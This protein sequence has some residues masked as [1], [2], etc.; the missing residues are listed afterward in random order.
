MSSTSSG[1]PND[2]VL[3]PSSG[4]GKGL[5]YRLQQALRSPSRA[6]SSEE[7]SAGSESG[8]LLHVEGAEGHGRG[9]STIDFTEGRNRPAP[10]S[11]PEDAGGAFLKS[12]HGRQVSIGAAF[13]QL[14]SMTQRAGDGSTLFRG[15]EEYVERTHARDEGW[16]W[17]ERGARGGGGG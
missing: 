8:D 2:A 10:R 6:G 12:G 13:A 4:G 5:H 11:Q 3:T 1:S 15:Y 9:T 17:V 14:Q 7:S 16:G